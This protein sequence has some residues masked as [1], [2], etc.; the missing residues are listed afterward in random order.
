MLIHWSISVIS[1]NIAQVETSILIFM[2]EIDTF[3]KYI[4]FYKFTIFKAKLKNNV[5]ECYP[6]TYHLGTQ[7]QFFKDNF[8]R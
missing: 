5:Y 4:D 2:K 7:S 8:F 1:Y 3:F 6:F